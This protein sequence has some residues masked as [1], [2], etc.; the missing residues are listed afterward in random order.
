[1]LILGLLLLLAAGALTA[2]MVLG[3]PGNVAVEV[4]GQKVSVFAIGEIFVLGVAT[5]VV[6]GL[7]LGLLLSGL[8]RS[9][10]KRR[11]RRAE[12]KGKRA[13]EQELQEEN[14]R[15]GRELDQQRRSGAAPSTPPTAPGRPDAGPPP[16]RTQPMGGAGGF[17]SPPS[18]SSHGGSSP[19]GGSIFDRPSGPPS[20]PPAAS[21]DSPQEGRRPLS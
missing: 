6:A 5:G 20:Q 21:P 15:L 4:F 1:M 11:E 14:A 10:R 17:G 7:A 8:R 2:G 13:R 9:G 3:N 19:S 16:D 18:G 12:V